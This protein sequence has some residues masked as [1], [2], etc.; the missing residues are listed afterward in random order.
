MFTRIIFSDNGV[1]RDFSTN[2]SNFQQGTE[3]LDYVAAEDKLFIG[4]PFPFNHKYFKVSVQNTNA[5]V[6]S[7]KLWDGSEFVDSVEI[8][9]ETSVGGIPI[10]QTGYISWVPDKEETWTREDT[11]IRNQE[12]V[13]GLGNITIY[14]NYWAEFTWDA[15]FDITTALSFVGNLFSNDD[16]LAAEFPDLVRSDTLNGFESGKTDWEEQHIKAA[17]LLIE[18]I[19]GQHVI[20]DGN[21]ILDRRAFKNSSVQKAAEIIYNAFGDDFEDQRLAALKEYQ[22]RLGRDILNLD[23]NSNARLDS[24]ERRVRQGRLIR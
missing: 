6:L 21:Q 15:D 5:A 4:S 20:T 11:V 16:D 19:Q 24:V 2:L 14:D 12:K 17:E 18:D 13:T 23:L 1:L 8:I 3:T 9:D 10:N 7:I 22:K